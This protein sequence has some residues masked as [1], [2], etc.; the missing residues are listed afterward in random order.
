MT[1]HKR[2]SPNEDPVTTHAR[3]NTAALAS[4]ANACAAAD[5]FLHDGSTPAPENLPADLVLTGTGAERVAVIGAET[6]DE[7]RF[8]S[9]EALRVY[10]RRCLVMSLSVRRESWTVPGP[11]DGRIDADTARLLLRRDSPVIDIVA[12]I[13]MNR[14]L[15]S[16]QLRYN[17]AN[18]R[19]QTFDHAL[20]ELDEHGVRYIADLF[21]VP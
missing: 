5:A 13:G 10:V 17:D 12:Q 2:H 21:A 9:H 1:T 6:P 11:S 3:L 18:D 8:S 16:P 7:R 4:H 14:S 15:V 20:H 19:M